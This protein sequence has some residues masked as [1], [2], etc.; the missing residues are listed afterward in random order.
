MIGNKVTD[1]LSVS[2][3]IQVD[4]I[5]A[6]KAS[7]FRSILCNRPDDEEPGQPPY[8]VIEAGAQAAGIEIRHQPV[9]SGRLTEA[10]VA[11]F[12]EAL[13]EMPAPVFAY[14]RSGTRCIML[15]ALAAS[16]E[17]PMAEV[18]EIAKKAG[19]DLGGG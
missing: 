11:G 1:G 17:Q 12:K 9:I 14:C 8:A 4:D 15:W 13:Q 6:I 18:L 2:R 3:Q 10:D 19:Y 7:G 5:E 16:A